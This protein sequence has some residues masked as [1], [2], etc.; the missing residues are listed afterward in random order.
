[1]FRLNAVLG[2]LHRNA[3][4]GGSDAIC[5]WAGWKTTCMSM[6]NIWCGEW[7]WSISIDWCVLSRRLLG[8]TLWSVRERWLSDFA[9]WLETHRMRSACKGLKHRG[10]NARRPARAPNT[11]PLHP[12][13]VFIIWMACKSFQPAPFPSARSLLSALVQHGL[14]CSSVGVNSSRTAKVKQLRANSIWTWT[15]V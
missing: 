2:V 7:G 10:E 11:I 15:A 13:L 1:M 14:V 5:A 12:R 8:T 9:W 6:L 4:A 3:C